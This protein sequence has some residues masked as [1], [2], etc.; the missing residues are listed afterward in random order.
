MIPQPQGEWSRE[1]CSNAFS[2]FIEEHFLFCFFCDVT[3][4][5]HG[6]EKCWQ[7]PKSRFDL[8]HRCG[9]FYCKAI[10]ILFHKCKFWHWQKSTVSLH[11]S[12]T[13]YFAG[14]FFRP[15]VNT[16]GPILKIRCSKTSASSECGSS[17]P[18]PLLI[19]S[20]ELCR[21]STRWGLLGSVDFIFYL[22]TG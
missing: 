1:M 12:H 6:G 10:H 13:R 21:W 15:N 14:Q 20:S 8:C 5:S 3:A 19:I 22:K 9:K 18:K 11:L 16:T 7:I 2:L 4:V 17:R